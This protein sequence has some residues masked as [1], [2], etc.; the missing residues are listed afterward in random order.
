MHTSEQLSFHLF[1]FL[2]RR[3][4][5][6][7]RGAWPVGMQIRGG[8]RI[9]DHGRARVKVKTARSR[10]SAALQLAVTL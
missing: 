1:I 6:L 8:G 7:F 4:D 2:A 9:A 3:S 10:Q 5:A